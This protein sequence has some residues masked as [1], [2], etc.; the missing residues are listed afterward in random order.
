MVRTGGNLFGYERN[1]S[2]SGE[3]DLIQYNLCDGVF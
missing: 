3:A 1:I 2:D